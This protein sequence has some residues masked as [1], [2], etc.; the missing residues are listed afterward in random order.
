MP[1]SRR[2]S[3]AP[4]PAPPRHHHRRACLAQAAG[5]FRPLRQL[6]R[7]DAGER[8]ALPARDHQQAQRRARGRPALGAAENLVAAAGAPAPARAVAAQAPKPEAVMEKAQ[9][10]RE[11]RVFRAARREGGGEIACGSPDL[12]PTLAPDL[13]QR[14]PPSF[15]RR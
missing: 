12:V 9:Q 7:D 4:G 10:L 8:A 2:R 5:A 15:P 13:A 11:Q 6:S 14:Q 3:V 1:R